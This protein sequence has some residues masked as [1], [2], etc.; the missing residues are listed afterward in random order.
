MELRELKPGE[1]FRREAGTYRYVV[2]TK[3]DSSGYTEQIWC[4]NLDG[5]NPYYHPSTEGV[6][7]LDFEPQNERFWVCFI[8][9]A[10][11]PTKIHP[12]EDLAIGEA[13]RLAVKTKKRVYILLATR[14]V[15]YIQPKVQEGFI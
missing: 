9:Q 1:M 14:Y 2:T 12:T 4:L 3:K 13:E 5:E 10:G 11:S 8:P 6:V 7:K 15:D